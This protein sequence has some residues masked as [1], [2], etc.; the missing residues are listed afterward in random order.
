MDDY[1][2]KKAYELLE[3]K[4]LANVAKNIA[5]GRDGI[6]KGTPM[7]T[8]SPRASTLKDTMDSLRQEG[9]V[10]NLEN[11]VKTTGPDTIGI[12]PEVR[13]KSKFFNLDKRIGQDITE[14]VEDVA[15]VAKN[16]EP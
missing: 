6:I 7:E 2:A 16:P 1:R 4:R 8:N 9:K 15:E 14:G 5:E 10:T 3:K 13:N 12:A 11:V